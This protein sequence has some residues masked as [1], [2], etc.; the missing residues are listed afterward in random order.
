MDINI[1]NIRPVVLEWLGSRDR[2]LGQLA[3]S[4]SE[5]GRLFGIKG[6]GHLEFLAVKGECDRKFLAALGGEGRVKW[7]D[8]ALWQAT[9]RDDRG[10]AKFREDTGWS[11]ELVGALMELLDSV[12]ILIRPKDV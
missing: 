11:P 2:L 7:I 6:P 8:V 3:N 10:L 9:L 12:A 1:S 5:A 4:R